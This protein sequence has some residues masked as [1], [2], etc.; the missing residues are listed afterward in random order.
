MTVCM[1]VVTK[2]GIIAGCDTRVVLWMNKNY[3][4]FKCRKFAINRKR[5]V[6]FL[7]SGMWYGVKENPVEVIE[8]RLK[9]L[10]EERDSILDVSKKAYDYLSPLYPKVSERG[11]QLQVCGFDSNQ[12][13]VYVVLSNPPPYRKNIEE[14]KN[15]AITGTEGVFEFTKQYGVPALGSMNLSEDEIIDAMKKYLQ[16]CVKFENEWSIRRNKPPMTDNRIN[17]L[18]V[19]ASDIEW[20][21]PRHYYPKDEKGLKKLQKRML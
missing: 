8:R 12:A 2:D 9:D 10:I 7:I 14:V 19:R 6:L 16:A 21:E 15:G 18:V 20:K 1:T 11:W 3:K 5:N 13:K 17:I 4:V